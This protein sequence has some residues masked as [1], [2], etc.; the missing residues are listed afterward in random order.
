MSARR[1]AAASLHAPSLLSLPFVPSERVIEVKL[2]WG[3]AAAVGGVGEGS[4]LTSSAVFISAWQVFLP[5]NTPVPSL[6]SY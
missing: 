3:G 6:D 4:T 2:R 1:R 5:G